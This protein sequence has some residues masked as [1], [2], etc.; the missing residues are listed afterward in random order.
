MYQHT[1]NIARRKFSKKSNYSK[2]PAFLS[3]CISQKFMEMI[4]SRLRL[5]SYYPWVYAICRIVGVCLLFSAQLVRSSK[6]IS[7]SD[8]RDIVTILDPSIQPNRSSK[9]ST[10]KPETNNLKT[11]APRTTAF[12][13]H[14][15]PL[16][17]S[18]QSSFF[19]RQIII[20]CSLVE[21]VPRHSYHPEFRNV[22]RVVLNHGVS[23]MRCV[24][25]IEFLHCHAFMSSMLPHADTPYK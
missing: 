14:H 3:N 8:S 13:H 4:I 23:C 6:Y 22:C 25:V 16:W 12:V 9:R 5:I 19:W 2:H 21:N 15:Y 7:Q 10:F 1:Q 17:S 20:Q 11:P 24:Q 18:K